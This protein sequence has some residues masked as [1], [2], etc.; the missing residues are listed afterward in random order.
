MATTT[1]RV[2]QGADACDR[3]LV[4]G[5]VGFLVGISM[6]ASSLELGTVAGDAIASSIGIAGPD[7][8]EA[9]PHLNPTAREDAVAGNCT[10]RCATVLQPVAPSRSPSDEVATPRL[11]QP[12]GRNR[13]PRTRE[14]SALSLTSQPFD[15]RDW[16]FIAGMSI[17]HH[18]RTN[19]LN[20]TTS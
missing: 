16:L 9:A 18:P 4:G 5:L 8:A 1:P 15:A 19:P 20:N 10:V 12:K 2:P 11:G 7:D 14:S 6:V 17:R 3:R 13:D